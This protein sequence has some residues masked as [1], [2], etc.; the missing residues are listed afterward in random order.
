MQLREFQL[1]SIAGFFSSINAE[2]AGQLRF[3]FD[4]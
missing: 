1:E 2:I 4:L 3:A